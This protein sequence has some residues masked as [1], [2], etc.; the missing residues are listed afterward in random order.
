MKNKRCGNCGSFEVKKTPY[1]GP[2]PW[3]D[4]P[5]VYLVKPIS[6]MQCE[7]CGETMGD[8]RNSEELDHAAEESIISQVRLFI[9]RII[10]REN[11]TQVELA[12]RVGV[13]PQYLSSLKSG[14]N[15]AGFQTFNFLK[16]LAVD[17]RAFKLASPSAKLIA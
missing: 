12:Q 9:D 1:T 2:F 15:I 14:A 16:V 11:C 4:F 10:Q 13:T 3:K 17:E 8:L 5:Q 7:I 6:I